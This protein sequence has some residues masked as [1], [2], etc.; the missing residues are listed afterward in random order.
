MKK[1]CIKTFKQIYKDPKTQ[2]K[3]EYI[4]KVAVIKDTNGYKY[5]IIN[6]EYMSI[7][8]KF[9]DTFNEAVEFLTKHPHNIENQKG[10]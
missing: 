7:W 3:K 2:E 10:E 1:Q 9:F 4:Y 8:N 5:R 6:L